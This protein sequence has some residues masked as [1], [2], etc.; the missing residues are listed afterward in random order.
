MKLVLLLIFNMFVFSVAKADTDFTVP[1]EILEEYKE[2]RSD[3]VESVLDGKPEVL[4]QY[5]PMLSPLDKELRISMISKFE[6]Q[7]DAVISKD[8]RYSFTTYEKELVCGFFVQSTAVLLERTYFESSE[9][10]N[11]YE[12]VYVRKNGD[13]FVGDNSSTTFSFFKSWAPRNQK[14]KTMKPP[15]CLYELNL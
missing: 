14:N 8:L 13:W 11:I 1:E 3:I 9:D 2:L 4:L 12:T 6:K 7:L 5:M 15:K 10:S